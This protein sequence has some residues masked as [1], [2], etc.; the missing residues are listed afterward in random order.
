[1]DKQTVSLILLQ[2]W[3]DLLKRAIAADMGDDLVNHSGPDEGDNVFSDGYKQKQ[4]SVEVLSS[5]HSTC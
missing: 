5:A 1:M 4:H 3:L 2:V